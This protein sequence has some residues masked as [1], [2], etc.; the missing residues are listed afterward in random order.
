MAGAEVLVQQII[1]RLR[2]VVDATVYCLDGL[3]ELGHQLRDAG[4]DVVVLGRK[5]G[6]DWD[7][8]KRLASDFQTRGI[9]VAHAHQYTP[10]FYSALAKMRGR[11][12][13]KLIFTEHGRHYPDV[14]S[15]KRRLANRLVLQRFAVA[16]TA[17]CDFSTQA[18]REIEGFPSTFTLRNG[19]DLTELPPRGNAQ[20]QT[21]LRASLGLDAD[22][23]YA[24]CIARFHPVKDHQ[25]LIRAWKRVHQL[26][27]HARLLL[28]GDGPERERIAQAVKENASSNQFE[29]SVEFWGIRDDVADILR[30]VDVFTLTSVSEAASLTL[31]EA[32]ASQCASVVTDVG[33]NGEHIRHS[34]E[35]FLV[36]R[37]DDEALAQR[38]CQMLEDRSLCREL[39]VAARDRVIAEFELADVVT[40]YR[41]LYLKHAGRSTTE[42]A[43]ARMPSGNQAGLHDEKPVAC[44]VEMK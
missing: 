6:L 29:S 44:M 25:T 16:S 11:C 31:L 39:G 32:M 14:V 1:Q 28:V 5:P 17:C 3:G 4:T 34:T 12:R 37:G 13:T 36:P 21:E 40:R 7:V 8:A 18:L 30:A 27:P 26:V 35:G 43:I 23:P 9:E 10:F 24:A 33:G 19:V 22:R 20:S 38:L 41:D 42:N 15:W 2:G